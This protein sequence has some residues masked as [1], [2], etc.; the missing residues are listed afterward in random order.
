M[1]EIYTSAIRLSMGHGAWGVELGAWSGMQKIEIRNKN[2]IRGN[3]VLIPR[4]E[5]LNLIN[6]SLA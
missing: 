4:N 2:E 6:A 3:K 5:W 1:Q